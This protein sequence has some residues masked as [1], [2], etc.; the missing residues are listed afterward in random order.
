MVKNLGTHDLTKVQVIDDLSLTFGNGAKIVPGSIDVKADSGLVV[1]TTY[2]GKGANTGL[3]V[4]SL[5]TL[6]VGTMRD[7]YL[8]IRV[9]V[10]EATTTTFN[11]VALG[12]ARGAENMMVSDT[13]TS[14]SDPDPDADMDPTND[15]ETTP[16]VLNNVPGESVIGVALSVKDTV[17]QANGSYNITYMAIVRNFGTGVLT[18]VQITDSL[19]QVFNTKTGAKFTKVGTPIASDVSEL[20]INQSFDGINDMELLV[21]PNSRL[22]AGASDTLTFTINVETDGRQTPYLNWVYVSAKSGEKVVTDRSTNGLLADV[23]GNGDP[24]E[25]TENLGT[26]LVIPAGTELFIPEGFSPNGDGI[27]DVFVIRNAPAG[28]RV[29]LEVYNRWMTQVYKDGDYKNDW[30]GI[31]NNGL[32]VGNTAQGLPDGTYFYVVKIEDG[33]Q[34]VRYMTI[35][36]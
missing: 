31:A 12:S 10:T 4:D 2:T 27:N 5:S 34:Y 28:K 14:G 20:A 3:L 24:T 30:T 13:S 6:P 15:S 7:I 17:R 21:S 22:N 33:K 1:N 36:R 16:I 32:R 23:N 11:N 18:N 19:S 9:D 35:T 26:P 29:T 25:A 8:T